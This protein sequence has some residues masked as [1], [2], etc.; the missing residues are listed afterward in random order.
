MRQLHFTVT[1]SYNDNSMV[2]MLNHHE[3]FVYDKW[4]SLLTIV[5]ELEAHQ[6]EQMKNLL[7]EKTSYMESAMLGADKPAYAASPTSSKPVDPDEP[8]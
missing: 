1:K 3:V 5:E 4:I 2:V 7:I 8:T 6:D